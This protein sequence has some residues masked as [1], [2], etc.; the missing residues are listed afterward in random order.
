MSTF[1]VEYTHK[2]RSMFL[3]IV[4]PDWDTAQ[5][6]LDSIKATGAILYESEVSEDDDGLL[7]DPDMISYTELYDAE[8]K[9]TEQD[10][11]NG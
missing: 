3:E 1:I 5:S 9:L 10:E 7:H 4:A 2:N 11:E 8:V 6:H